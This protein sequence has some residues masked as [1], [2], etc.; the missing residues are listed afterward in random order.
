VRNFDYKIIYGL[1]MKDLIWVRFFIGG[2]G[3]CIKKTPKL[4]SER[5]GFGYSKSMP[6]PFGWRI[7]FLKASK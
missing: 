2:Y 1:I 3:F 6:L 7:G 5:S 4:F